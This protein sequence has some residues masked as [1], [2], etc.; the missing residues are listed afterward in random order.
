MALIAGSTGLVGGHCL[1]FLQQDASFARVI[2]LTRR[3]LESLDSLDLSS[4]TDV[5]CALGTTIRKAGSREAFRR[6]DFDYP[7]AIA[8]KA[9]A[10]SAFTLVSSVD[11]TPKSP[12]FHLRVKGELEAALSALPFD[13][14]HLFRPG[15]L[16]GERGERRMGEAAGIAI[17]QALR[18]ALAGPLRKYRAIPAEDVARAMVTASKQGAPGRHVYHFGEIMSLS[19]VN[20]SP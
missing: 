18:F 17:T 14:V 16:I 2:A 8:R 19:R 13:A 11:A 20:H 5:F 15:F 10:A 1:R 6:V 9:A 7:L 12:N 4:A 3:D